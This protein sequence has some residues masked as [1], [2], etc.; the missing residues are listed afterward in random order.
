M[1]TD[2]WRAFDDE[3]DES[4]QEVVR[5]AFQ[6]LDVEALGRVDGSQDPMT[7]EDLEGLYFETLGGD[8]LPAPDPTLTRPLYLAD[9]LRCSL[10]AYERVLLYHD[11]NELYGKYEG[12]SRSFDGDPKTFANGTVDRFSWSG[13][14][15]T[16]VPLSGTYVYDFETEARR[17]TLP[18]DADVVGTE[19]FIVRTWLPR[20]AVWD[21]E[22]LTFNQDYQLE[23][24]IPIAADELL[25]IYPVW[26]EFVTASGDMSNDLVA[27]L[28]L[29]QMGL[30]DDRT[31]ELCEQGLP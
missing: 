15:I 26:R 30:W 27:S 14:L 5:D 29:W 4:L 23:L 8:A 2:A 22:G 19:G 24:Y 1:L 7:E 31:S 12:Y 17:F 25:H 21:N 11:Q 10:E 16:F 18:D 3:G 9:R 6:V 20:P 28:T 13:Q